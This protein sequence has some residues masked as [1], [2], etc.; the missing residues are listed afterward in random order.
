MPDGKSCPT[1]FM[2]KYRFFTQC[3]LVS[4]P[5]GD[6]ALHMSP[7]VKVGQITGVSS[8]AGGSRPSFGFQ[9]PPAVATGCAFS[10]MNRDTFPF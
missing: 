5:A 6:V 2:N 7:Q 3:T 9:P 10:G 1:P 4:Q 8:T